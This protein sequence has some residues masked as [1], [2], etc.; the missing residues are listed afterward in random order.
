V[1]LIGVAYLAIIIPLDIHLHANYGY[2]GNAIS[3]QASIVDYLGQWP[4]RIVWIFLLGQLAMA[5]LMLPFEFSR[6]DRALP[7]LAHP[8]HN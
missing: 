7:D 4:L 1:T 5:L 6:R 3:K 2:V 8:Q